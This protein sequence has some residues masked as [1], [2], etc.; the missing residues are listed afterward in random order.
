MIRLAEEHDLPAIL[1]IYRKARIYMADNGNASQWGDTYPPAA[2]VQED[3]ARRQLY[4]ITDEK[5]VFCAPET[6]HQTHANPLSFDTH[7]TLTET[8]SSDMHTCTDFTVHAVFAFL[9]GK[10]PDYDRIE[11]GHWISD[12]DYRAVHRVASDGTLRGVVRQCM[13]YCKSQ[14]GHLRIDTHQDNLVMQHQLEKNH[15]QRRGIIRLADGSPRIA[16]EWT[17]EQ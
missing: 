12:S 5:P 17:D 13:D 6:T 2:V 8:F 10:E 7:Q 16:Y 4:V 3:I 11:A 9:P 15:F 14:C 1:E